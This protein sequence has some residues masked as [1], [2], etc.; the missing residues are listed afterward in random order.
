MLFLGLDRWGNSQDTLHYYYYYYY[1]QLRL[2]SKVLL[3]QDKTTTNINNCNGFPPDLFPTY[4]F[5]LLLLLD[6]LLPN[7]QKQMAVYLTVGVNCTVSG[8]SF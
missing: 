8:F 6:L 7:Q 3:L 2:L 1:L 4:V 5:Y